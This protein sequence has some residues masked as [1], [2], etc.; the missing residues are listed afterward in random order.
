MAEN[1]VGTAAQAISQTTVMVIW[2]D[3]LDGVLYLIYAGQTD[4]AGASLVGA[5]AAGEQEFLVHG[6]TPG[7]TYRFWAVAIAADGSQSEP[8]GPAEAA[9]WS[10]IPAA[11]PFY[12]EPRGSASLW[13][14]WKDVEGAS[15]Y[16]I[17][18]GET[19]SFS[20]AALVLAVPQGREVA[21]IDGLTPE[22]EYF[23]WIV[24]RAGESQGEAAG[25]VQAATRA[26]V[27]GALDI[28][29][30]QNALWAWAA[31]VVAAAGLAD[32]VIWANQDGTRP[33]SRHVQLSLAGPMIPGAS[34]SLA[35][36]AG[37]DQV[38]EQRGLR[39]FLVSVNAYAPADPGAIALTARLQ[40][41]LFNPTLRLPLENAHIGIGKVSDVRDLSAF[42]ETRWESRMQ[43]DFVIFATFRDEV[44]QDLI[45]DVVITN[46][47]PA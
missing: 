7:T 41:S 43:F 23:V 19:S 45:E 39:T 28:D 2:T 14:S 13:L 16:L 36:T 29:G 3:S 44:V 1:P 22:H 20:E 30:I 31:G 25:P 26:Q 46:I 8:D 17:Y 15:L 4:F 5:A 10:L 38:F 11:H 34:D 12:A 9:T 33:Q 42:L 32:K 35:P 24:A 21:V 18:R 47:T 6:L 27:G 40:A 37:A